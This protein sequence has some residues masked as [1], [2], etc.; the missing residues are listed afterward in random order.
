MFGGCAVAE[1]LLLAPPP[2]PPLA[3]PLA[4]PLALLWLPRMLDK[5]VADALERRMRPKAAPPVTAVPPPRTSASSDCRSGQDWEEVRLEDR[6]GLPMEFMDATEFCDMESARDR[7]R[8]AKPVGAPLPP[9]VLCW[10]WM[11]VLEVLTR[12]PR[13]PSGS[14]AAMSTPP[15]PYCDADATVPA[16][17]T[18]PPP[19]PPPLLLVVEEEQVLEQ[20]LAALLPAA[21]AAAAL[22]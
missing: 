1:A 21:A 4:L 2:P 10:L 3:P 11:E 6:R 9:P 15:R 16:I 20:V 22:T 12:S 14:M 18:P 19:P 8:R 5:A 7:L 17:P 13:P